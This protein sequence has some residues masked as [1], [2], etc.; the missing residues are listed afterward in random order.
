MDDPKAII[1]R[2][3]RADPEAMNQL[4]AHLCPAIQRQVNAAIISR[5]LVPRLAR[6]AVLDMTRTVLEAIF[7]NQGAGIRSWDPQIPLHSW[8]AH[9][10]DAHTAAALNPICPPPQTPT[11]PIDIDL[12]WRAALSNDRDALP[13]APQ[14]MEHALVMLR[15]MME[16]EH[17]A[18]SAGLLQAFLQPSPKAEPPPG[19]SAATGTKKKPRV[20]LD[21][22]QKRGVY[23]SAGLTVVLLT[24]MAVDRM[25]SDPVADLVPSFALKARVG[26]GNTP[27]T[28]TEGERIEVRLRPSVP[29]DPHAID[30]Y[31]RPIMLSVEALAKT[32]E[33]EMV[34]WA[35]ELTHSNTGEFVLS[36]Q[37]GTSLPV[38]PGFWEIFLVIGPRNDLD[39]LSSR[40]VVDSEPPPPPFERVRY[41]I[42]VLSRTSTTAVN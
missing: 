2:A 14:Q 6:Q 13:V 31:G 41:K 8:V 29:I 39:M 25:T 15:P 12:W 5:G 3:L 35:Y 36:G 27:P 22:K 38:Q 34:N 10:A 1:D 32:P 4:I 26:K 9:V 42:Q 11:S 17:Q 23:L 30:K 19:A 7:M 28:Y 24:G 20:P 33:G 37:I 40:A 16:H 21:P 18:L